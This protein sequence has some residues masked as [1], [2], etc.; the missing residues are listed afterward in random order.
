M[1]RIHSLD[2]E[3]TEQFDVDSVRQ[4][5]TAPATVW[6]DYVRGTVWSLLQEGLSVT[7]WDGA[8]VGDVPFWKGLSSSVAVVG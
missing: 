1:I 7:E 5:P 4:L 3:Q 2:F 8:M 6:I